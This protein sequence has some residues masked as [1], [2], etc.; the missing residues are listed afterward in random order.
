MCHVIIARSLLAENVVD[1]PQVLE[2]LAQAEKIEPAD[3]D[4]YYL[5]GKAYAAMN[6][7]DEAVTAL[8]RAIELRPAETSAHYQLG[9]TYQ[10][11]GQPALA[12]EQMERMQF[13][14]DSP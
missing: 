7:Y 2:E 12:R 3:F 11:M 1:Y 8:R 6:R 9:L 4:V 14:R 13:L 10:K 5:R